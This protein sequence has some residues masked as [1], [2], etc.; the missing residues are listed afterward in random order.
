MTQKIEKMSVKEFRE[1]GYLQEVNRM[2]L[3]R[4]GLAMEM[5][6]VDKDLYQG[7][8][9]VK[10]YNENLNKVKKKIEESNDF[11]ESEK[12]M[13]DGILA[14]ADDGWMF[15]QVWDYRDDPEGML[16]GE[17][18]DKHIERG[19]RIVGEMIEKAKVRNKKYG[20][21][22]QP[23]KKH[24]ITDDGMKEIEVDEID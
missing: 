5:L 16:F 22:I 18:T 10:E 14:L 3:H 13:L 20:F 24:K 2:F 12:D 7:D 23:L 6:I 17:I 11:T 1:Q 4:L 19:E 9:T 8:L 15:G 21:N